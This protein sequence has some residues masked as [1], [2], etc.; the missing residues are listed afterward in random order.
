MEFPDAAMRGRNARRDRTRNLD[1]PG[2]ASADD[3]AD[4]EAPLSTERR[5]T[6]PPLDLAVGVRNDGPS[7][8]AT[9]TMESS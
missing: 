1:V 3:V 9:A 4:G 2:R 7:P 8:T 6:E 5:V